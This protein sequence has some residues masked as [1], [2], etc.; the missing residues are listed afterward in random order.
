MP[1]DFTIDRIL[2]K[3]EVEKPRSPIYNK[4]FDNNPWTSKYPTSLTFNPS[5]HNRQPSP[6][7]ATY[8]I[9]LNLTNSS[10]TTTVFYPENAV[11]PAQAFNSIN[12]S[13]FYP[14]SVESEST[15]SSNDVQS[16]SEWFSR[17][18]FENK[19]TS[20]SESDGF[21]LNLSQKS[22][23][24]VVLPLQTSPKCFQCSVCSNSFVNCELLNVRWK[25]CGL[26]S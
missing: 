16:P 7:I 15:S 3:S 8:P 21:C 11:K 23:V 26:L 10:S 25:I 14:A 2:S 4:V 20:S 18:F 13:D 19:S 22:A 6:T 5:S 1:T 17:S 24:I 12:K 9:N